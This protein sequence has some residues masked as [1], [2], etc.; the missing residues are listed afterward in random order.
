MNVNVHVHV[1]LDGINDYNEKIILGFIYLYSYI[2]IASTF[3]SLGNRFID[4]H[5]NKPNNKCPNNMCP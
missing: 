4:S 2:Y 3:T 5:R 1:W